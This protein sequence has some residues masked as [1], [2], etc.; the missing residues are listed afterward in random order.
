MAFGGLNR[1]EGFNYIMSEDLVDWFLSI[2]EGREW[3]EG[4]LEEKGFKMD[5]RSVSSTDLG[6]NFIAVDTGFAIP[7][8]RT[9]TYV[10][11]SKCSL[12]TKAI[13][14]IKSQG[15]F[16]AFVLE[17]FKPV[18][19]SE[20]PIARKLGTAILASA[21]WAQ[22]GKDVKKSIKNNKL[23]KTVLET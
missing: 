5:L 8:S 20:L 7:L 16:G 15:G 4:N 17:G 18:C 22:H 1:T 14:L 11:V 6:L 3:L 9:T 23:A 2:D 21:W 10:P 12:F 19:T 13:K